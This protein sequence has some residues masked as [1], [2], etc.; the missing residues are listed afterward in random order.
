MSTNDERDRETAE[1]AGR[2]EPISADCSLESTE[3]YVARSPGTGAPGDGSRKTCSAGP[4]P[5][6]MKTASKNGKSRVNG[7]RLTR[8]EL[9]AAHDRA[10][11]RL[12]KMTP[13]EGFATLVKAGIYTP[14]GKLTPRYGG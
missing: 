3:S 4:A 13:Q 10:L 14:E 9:L 2:N 8:A 11:K 5:V 6:K 7:T 1:N 12:S